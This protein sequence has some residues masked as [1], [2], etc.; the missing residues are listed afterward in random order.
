MKEK[1]TITR[2]KYKHPLYIYLDDELEKFVSELAIYRGENKSVVIR[3]LIR[4]A[5]REVSNEQTV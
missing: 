5:K 2:K 1:K 4:K 3:S